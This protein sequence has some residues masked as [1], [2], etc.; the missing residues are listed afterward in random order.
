ML[1]INIL[2][3][4]LSAFREFSLG[5]LCQVCFTD[6]TALKSVNCTKAQSIDSVSEVVTLYFVMRIHHS[7]QISDVL[8][9]KSFKHASQL[10]WRTSWGHIFILTNDGTINTKFSNADSG[11]AKSFAILYVCV[12]EGTTRTIKLPFNRKKRPGGFRVTWSGANCV[13]SQ[14]GK[15]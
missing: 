13:L 4:D 6:N 14:K 7:A 11:S 2:R 15:F 10:R 3:T 8:L 1:S 12:V 9:H 5:V